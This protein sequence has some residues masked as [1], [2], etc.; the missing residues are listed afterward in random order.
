MSLGSSG[1]LQSYKIKILMESFVRA[2]TEPICVETQSCLEEEEEGV[3]GLKEE[4]GMDKR[5]RQ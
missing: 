2:P 1:N 4:R 3:Q 5:R